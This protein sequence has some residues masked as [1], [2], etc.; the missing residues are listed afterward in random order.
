MAIGEPSSP[1]R[2][3]K[4]VPA[5]AT[6]VYVWSTA[7]LSAL[8]GQYILWTNLNTRKYSFFSSP[9]K[10]ESSDVEMCQCTTSPF[11]SKLVTELNSKSTKRATIQFVHK[12]NRGYYYMS[13]ACQ[14]PKTDGTMKKNLVLVALY[15][16]DRLLPI[17]N[18]TLQQSNSRRA[19]NCTLHGGPPW[20]AE[21][22][23]ILVAVGFS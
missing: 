13:H 21:M 2:A 14:K 9:S 8:E 20:M 23:L 12:Q 17:M 11:T 4:V 22:F 18:F 15:S 10:A 6:R 5:T 1:L 19:R 7:L 16:L 3:N